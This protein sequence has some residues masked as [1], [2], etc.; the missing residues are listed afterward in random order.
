MCFCLWHIIN[1]YSHVNFSL[2][3]EKSIYLI[4][5]CIHEELEG[6]VGR[7][8]GVNSWK[9]LY[10][11]TFTTEKKALLWWLQH[12]NPKVARFNSVTTPV[13]LRRG[14]WGVKISFFFLLALV[15]YCEQSRASE[16]SSRATWLVERSVMGAPPTPGS[17]RNHFTF[18]EWKSEA[19]SR[20][21]EQ[22]LK[23]TSFSVAR[24]KKKIL[25]KRYSE[26]RLIQNGRKFA[27]SLFVLYDSESVV[28]RRRVRLM[29]K[30]A[31]I[32]VQCRGHKSL[33][34]Y[35]GIALHSRKWGSMGEPYLDFTT[36]RLQSRAQALPSVCPLVCPDSCRNMFN[37]TIRKCS[38]AG[39]LSFPHVK[40]TTACIF[41]HTMS[42][43]TMLRGKKK[44]HLNPTYLMFSPCFVAHWS[45][46]WNTI[47]WHH[48]FL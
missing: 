19:S 1:V 27:L 47:F 34:H 10:P 24:L 36:A 31:R 4:S 29:G 40:W 22:R 21:F 2:R 30:S 9:W 3:R 16:L 46:W 42:Q 32:C 41:K 44:P 37:F 5:A 35:G 39:P 45:T 18:F 15:N 43:H 28:K 14:V 48:C 11:G 38:T 26:V 8:G 7:V 13:K 17:L 20:R 12:L 25:S 6:A 33:L 23:M